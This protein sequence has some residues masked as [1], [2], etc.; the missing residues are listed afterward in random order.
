MAESRVGAFGP[1]NTETAIDK[2]A[3][4]STEENNE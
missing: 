3:G 2:H 1:V 4:V